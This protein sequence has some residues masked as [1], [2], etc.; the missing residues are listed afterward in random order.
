MQFHITENGALRVQIS[1]AELAQMGLSFETLDHASAATRIA[2]DT[3]LLSAEA[4]TGFVPTQPLLIEAVPVE[5][6]CL[7]LFTPDRVRPQL[8]LRRTA[9]TGVWRFDDTDALLGFQAAL[10]PF[11]ASLKRRQPL[12]AASLYQQENAYRLIVYAPSMLP[13]GVVPTLS[14]F[15]EHI[16]TGTTAAATEEHGTPIC[17][18]DALLKLAL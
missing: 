2:L 12:C 18:R 15:A 11:A 5:D 6:G 14:E 10:R 8:K 3:V 9:P 4:Q 16:G 17:L 7:L 13:R 1:D